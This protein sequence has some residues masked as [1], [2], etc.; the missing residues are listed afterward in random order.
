[1]GTQSTGNLLGPLHD[2]F[3]SWVYEMS[4]TELLCKVLSLTSNFGNNDGGCAA[5]FQALDNAQADW[6]SSHN[7]G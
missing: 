5:R 3:I 7:K 4:S 1:M 6:A 2:V